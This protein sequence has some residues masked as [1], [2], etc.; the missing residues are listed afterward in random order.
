[1]IPLEEALAEL[2]A[3]CPVLPVE[4]LDLRSA[5]GCVAA[6][7][8][9]SAHDVPP[10]ACSAVDGYALRAAD[11]A[12]ADAG[13]PVS[14]AVLGSVPAGRTASGPLT[15]GAT[16]KV[17]TGAPV[18]DGA[19]TVVMVE[20][21]SAS[22]DHPAASA[23]DQV[24]IFAAA[25]A[26]TAV[27]SAGSNVAAG[28]VLVSEGTTLG[29]AHL[30][31]LASAGI[32]AVE[33][34]PKP[35]VGVLVTGD[36]LV[37]EDRELQPGEIYESNGAMVMALLTESSF[38]PRWLGVA[39][40]QPDTLADTLLAAAQECDVI[41]TT[42]GVSMGDADPVKAAL[43][44]L[45]RLHAM[46]VSIRPAKPFAYGLL[47]GPGRPVPVLGLPGNPVSS[48]VS[49]ELLARPVLRS[50]AGHVEL[51]RPDVLAVTDAPLAA[52]GTDGRTTYLRVRGRFG[53]D[54]RWHVLP[55]SGQD[56]HQLAATADAN[57]LAELA[58]HSRIE[59][60]GE[61]RV[62][63]LRWDH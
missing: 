54:G 35:Q 8:L 9:V 16:W 37:T 46:Q 29:P 32:R 43:G 11:V 1:V 60:G 6:K 48:L 15:A 61:V 18:P 13:R 7:D 41:V 52:T 51:H 19:D 53:T 21:S 24:L 22:L 47:D 31:V 40:D 3:A 12:H 23:G 39:R 42:G 49:F 58:P 28:D 50:M 55:V 20:S 44:R 34:H 63:S 30:A 59:A 57:G 10:F 14:L 25:A 56:S 45:G 27:R 36:E 33:V 26:G 38:E 5:L 4:H 17:M 2:L 62:R